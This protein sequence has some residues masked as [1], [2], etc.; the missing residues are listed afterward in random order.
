MLAFFSVGCAKLE[1]MELTEEEKNLCVDY[2]A[3]AVLKHDKN[4]IDRMVS[5]EIETEE[6]TTSVQAEQS[7]GEAGQTTVQEEALVTTMNDIFGLAGLDIQ[8][9]GCEVLDSYPSDGQNLG[10]S[11]VAVKGCKLLVTK[12]H[13]V[14]TAGNDVSVNFMDSGA[15]YKGVVNDN[16]KMN[17]QVTALLDAFNTYEGIIPAGGSQD[18]VLVFQINENDANSITSVKLNITYNDKQ[19]TVVIR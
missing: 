12:F 2:A 10:M 16:V 1:M 4:N 18:L 9:A 19:G 15:T 11:M 8:A 7:S 13:I 3:N 6:E 14:N 5:V 17:A